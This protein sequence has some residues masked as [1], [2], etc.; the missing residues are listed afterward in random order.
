MGNKDITD[1]NEAQ[2][3][4]RAASKRRIVEHMKGQGLRIDS[5]NAIGG[6]SKKAPFVMQTLADPVHV[7]FLI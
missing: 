2:L 6:I 1:F 4:K 3:R 5:V 7:H